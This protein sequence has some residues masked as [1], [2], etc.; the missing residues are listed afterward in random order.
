[1][2][3]VAPSLS[4]D[5]LMLL[6]IRPRHVANILAGRKTVELRRS[7]PAITAGQP[8]AI[9]STLPEAAMVALCIVGD[10]EVDTPDAV[11]RRVGASTAIELSEYQRY[12]HGTQTAVA[13]HLTQVVK[14]NLPVSLD[15]LRV[16]GSFQPPQTWHFLDANQ[17]ER[18]V[19]SHPARETLDDWFAGRGAVSVDPELRLPSH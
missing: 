2:T 13:L 3:V 9:Y 6:S 4:T 16:G 15:H 10:I 19:G 12:F 14:L 5:R 8:V 17:I 7:R 1:M 11:W 18:L